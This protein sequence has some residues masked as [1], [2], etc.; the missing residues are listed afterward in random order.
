MQSSHFCLKISKFFK[1]LSWWLYNFYTL[2]FLFSLQ[3]STLSKTKSKP[4][5]PPPENLYKYLMTSARNSK[6]KDCTFFFSMLITWWKYMQNENTAKFTLTFYIYKCQSKNWKQNRD[7]SGS[8]VNHR[9]RCSQRLVTEILKPPLE[10][11]VTSTQ[12]IWC[13]NY[14]GNDKSFFHFS[15]YFHSFIRH[16][17]M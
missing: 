15:L 11:F 5:N 10:P 8:K 9:E 3:T 13:R 14:F 1:I 12:W 16:F 2:F 17:I 6:Q 4:P 7:E